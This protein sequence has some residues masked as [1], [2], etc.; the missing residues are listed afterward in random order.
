MSNILGNNSLFFFEKGAAK[1]KFPSIPKGAKIR[2]TFEHM[3]PKTGV[4]MTG[5]FGE[6]S[7]PLKKEGPGKLKRLARGVLG[8]AGVLGLS[9]AGGAAAASAGSPY[10]VNP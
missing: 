2:G 9:V 6:G 8:T 5:S 10:E 1:F 4:K 3:D 7:E